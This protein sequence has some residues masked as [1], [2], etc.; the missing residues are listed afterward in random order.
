MFSLSLLFAL[1]GFVLSSEHHS[2]DGTSL[3]EMIRKDPNALLSIFDTADKTKVDKIIKLVETLITEGQA[4]I[5]AI[6]SDIKRC[7]AE[8]KSHQ[9]IY[10]R[11]VAQAAAF[12]KGYEEAEKEMSKALGVKNSA[13]KAF[14]RESPAL[15]KEILVFQKVLRI[16]HSLL[17]NGGKGL[18]EE[19]AAE[20]RAFIS[21]N[22]QAD[23][24]KVK[25]IIDLVAKLL[26]VSKIEL[27]SLKKAVADATSAHDDA[28]I[29][30]NK[31]FGKWVAGQA[32][33]VGARRQLDLVRGKCETGLRIGT[34]RKKVVNGEITTLRAVILL[35]KQ[36]Y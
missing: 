11:A 14:D 19:D 21:L 26:S 23:P 2:S 18:A 6:N 28:V 4:E 31:A 12:K 29:A 16:L 30:R 35:L 9:D 3:L 24:V 25:R 36:V 17:P 7:A 5:N 8:V 32:A 13:I 22:D 34:A 27:A 15:N 1:I 33:L 20:I 10:I